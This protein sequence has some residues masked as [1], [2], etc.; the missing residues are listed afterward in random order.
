MS[1]IIPWPG[2]A[3]AVDRAGSLKVAL[4]AVAHAPPFH[5]PLAFRPHTLRPHAVSPIARLPLASLFALTVLVDTFVAL[6]NE[7]VAL[8]VVRPQM[9]FHLGLHC[10]H[11]VL[12]DDV[13][14]PV[15]VTRC[16]KTVPW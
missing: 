2:V 11:G 10:R 14:S 6:A 13:G 15:G 4:P 12:V 5:S 9:R 16:V 1:T 3:S 8:F 7:L